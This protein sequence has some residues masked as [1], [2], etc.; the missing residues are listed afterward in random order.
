MLKILHTILVCIFILGSCFKSFTQENETL[1]IPEQPWNVQCSDGRCFMQVAVAFERGRG[2]E[3]AGLAVSFD[4]KKNI[5][6]Y[7]SVYVPADAIKDEGLTIAFVDSVPEGESFKLKPATDLYSIP[8]M[9]CTEEY[10]VSRVHPELDNGD[11]T[12]LDLFQELK[13]RHHLWVGFKRTGE[14]EL[15]RIMI[16]VYRF[17]I[18]LREIENK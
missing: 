5:C 10:C 1:Q 7:V 3:Q 2:Q 18:E 8:I 15:V 14:K 12:S 17:V 13:V 4:Q 9:E 16:P 11:G 6:Q